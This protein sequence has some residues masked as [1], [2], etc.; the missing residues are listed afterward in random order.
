MLI[1]LSAMF[2]FSRRGPPWVLFEVSSGGLFPFF[3]F[4][5]NH[6]QIPD[7]SG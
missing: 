4:F 1:D 3:D 6:D 2:Y 5:G 7:D